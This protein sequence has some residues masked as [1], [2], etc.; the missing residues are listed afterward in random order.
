MVCVHVCLC[1]FVGVCGQNISKTKSCRKLKLDILFR[2]YKCI[3]HE[4]FWQKRFEKC[5][6]IEKI[7]HFFVIFSIKMAKVFNY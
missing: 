3:R 4:D 2:Y 1:V 7:F 6:F 5:D